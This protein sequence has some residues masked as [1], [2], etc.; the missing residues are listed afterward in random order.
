MSLRVIFLLLL[1][2][3]TA[4][5]FFWNSQKPVFTVILDPAGDAQHTG[6]SLSLGYERSVTLYIAGEIQRIILQ[7]CP[8]IT[9]LLTRQPGQLT[10]FLQTAQFANR[11]PAT[12]FVRLHAFEEKTHTIPSI[13]VYRYRHEDEVPLTH[14][15]AFVPAQQAYRYALTT[16]TA[17]TATINQLL[18]QDIYRTQCHYGGIFGIPL[19]ALVGIQVPAVVIDSG[20][21]NQQSVSVTA[22]IIADCIQSL[23]AS[24][25][26]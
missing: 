23:Y 10:N 13:T 2:F 21:T 20:V 1:Y 16:T 3:P 22:Q 11:V 7:R 19:I 25:R 14:Q 9:V 6:R 5:A 12:L 24:V 4:T 15:L 8:H 17:Y 26:T 18:S